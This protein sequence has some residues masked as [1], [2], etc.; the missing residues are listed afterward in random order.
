LRKT[1]PKKG[2]YNGLPVAGA[3][4]VQ[5]IVQRLQPQAN[6]KSIQVLLSASEQN[7]VSVYADK[8]RFE[9]IVENLLSNAIKFSPHRTTIEISVERKKP[10]SDR[11]R[12]DETVSSVILRV[13]DEGPGLTDTDKTKLFDKFARLS[14]R[15]TGGEPSTGLGLA[16]VKQLAE[17]MNGSIWCD[18]REGEGAT[19]FVQLPEIFEKPHESSF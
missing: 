4:A 7:D 19:F 5:R 6:A 3:P 11:L 16:I 15:P 18:S 10:N 12:G 14:A 8:R 9:Q 2:L 1:A 17:A 13:R